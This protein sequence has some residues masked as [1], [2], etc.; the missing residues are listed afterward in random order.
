ME[1]QA[2]EPVL[3]REYRSGIKKILLGVDLIL[4]LVNIIKR[5]TYW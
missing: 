1:G 2:G 3:R 4:Y 5:K